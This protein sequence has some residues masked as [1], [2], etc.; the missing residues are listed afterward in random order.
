MT[1]AAVVAVDFGAMLTSLNKTNTNII[2]YVY[3]NIL[4]EREYKSF[5]SSITRGKRRGKKTSR[6]CLKQVLKARQITAIIAETLK[7]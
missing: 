3:T 1:V 6:K 2:I 4:N 5:I 7:I